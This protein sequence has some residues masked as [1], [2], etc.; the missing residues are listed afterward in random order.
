MPALTHGNFEQ[1]N[2]Q[3][4]AGFAARCLKQG[5]FLGG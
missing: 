5:L 2:K 4:G 1:I 3:I